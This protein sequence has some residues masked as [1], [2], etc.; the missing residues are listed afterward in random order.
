MRALFR[1]ILDARTWGRIAYLL[2]ALPLGVAE[3]SFLVTAISFGFGTAITLIGLPVL[4]ASVYAW[5]W[6]AQLERRI[7]GRLT[8][9][10]IPS[11]YRSDPAAA[12][13]WQRLAARLAD[14]ATWKDLAFLLLQ[15]PLGI[16]S[17]S[18]TVVVFGF[19][20]RLLFAP[21]Y[22]HPFADGDWISVLGLDSLG[23][24]FAAV[25]VGALILLFGIPLLG[26]LGRLYTW[27]AA[28]LLGSNADPALTRQVSELSDARS[29]IIAAGDAERR[30]IERDLHD[31]AQQ[32][33]VALALNLRMA[34]QRA[35]AGDPSA[36]ELV[37]AA[38]DEAQL[39][40]KEL[41][42]LARGIHPAILTNR[43]LPAALEDLASRSTVPVEVVSAPDSRLP[44][45]VEAA[46]YFVVSECLANI[47][48]HAEA[49]AATVA[50]ASDASHVT[51]VVTDDGVGGASL[52]GGS[53]IQGL[54]DR[55]GALSGSISVDSPQGEG[56]RVTASI[57]LTATAAAESTP[58][59][60]RPAPRVLT[61]A[62]ADELQAGR[63][64]RL[65][66]RAAS[67]GVVAGVLVVIWALTGT[68]LP[69]I[70]WPLLGIGFV[71]ALD[72][73]YVFSTRPLRGSDL[74]G[75]ADREE[76]LRRLVRRR[77]LRH[78]AGALAIVNILIVGVWAAS[79]SPDYFWPA[80]VM[81][82][83]LAAVGLMALPDPART[84]G[85]A[86]SAPL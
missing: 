28:Q 76:E 86:V 72:A 56:T 60:G 25:P 8:Q 38:G 61:D 82:A 78:I 31:G 27:L 84:R 45:P 5:R 10:E 73:W 1:Q 70:A 68:E 35:E 30:R 48:K 77:R 32:R 19:G 43:G 12:R 34:E 58:D 42:D 23:W 26:H 81:L 6:L 3:F 57:P 39:A 69:W 2:L 7:I 75:T 85:A 65:T 74:A 22:W 62:E 71:A 40:L 49:S 59:P 64:H 20:L 54:A 33:L 18:I 66:L 37:R 16:L 80:W 41:R 44:G 24:A 51:I 63:R 11:P 50:V 14:P 53:G 83:S 21:I 52:D 79:G 17:F 55:V 15:L 67:L 47:G 46:A 9:V 13:W 36:A 29:R 4:V